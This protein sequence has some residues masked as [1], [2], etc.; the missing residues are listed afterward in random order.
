MDEVDFRRYH[1]GQWVGSAGP[2]LPAGVWASLPRQEPPGNDQPVVLTLWG[3]Y[4]RS[5]ALV[6]A[7]L[8]GGVFF[9][10]SAEKASDD[11]IAAAIR[12]ASQ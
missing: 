8:D 11:D 7:T 1:L 9:G 6:G 3:N 12:A 5:A 2:W 4:K 10:W